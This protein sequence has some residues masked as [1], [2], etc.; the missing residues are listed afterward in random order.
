MP[1]QQEELA[2]WRA[3][4]FRG[5]VVSAWIAMFLFLFASVDQLKTRGIEPGFWHFVNVSAV[6]LRW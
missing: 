4:A 6:F 5:G 2:N 3:T 1:G